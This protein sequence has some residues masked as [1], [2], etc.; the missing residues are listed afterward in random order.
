MQNSTAEKIPVEEIFGTEE[1]I[2]FDKYELKNLV[3]EIIDMVKDGKKLTFL[4]LYA[5]RVILPKL[6]ELPKILM[7]VNL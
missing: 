2:T 4:R 6:T 1:S 3:Q 7:Q 5:M